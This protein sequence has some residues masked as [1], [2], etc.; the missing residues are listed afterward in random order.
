[1]ILS[2]GKAS[3]FVKNSPSSRVKISLVTATTDSRLRSFLHRAN[4]NAVLPDP[5]N[6]ANE[7]QRMRYQYRVD[8]QIDHNTI[9]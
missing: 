8:I 1:M 9:G 7:M 3:C 2:L 5:T 4:I 6:T